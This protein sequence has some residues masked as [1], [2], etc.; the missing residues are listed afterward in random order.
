MTEASHG[1]QNSERRPEKVYAALDAVAHLEQEERYDELIPVYQDLVGRFPE[2][3]ELLFKMATLMMRNG[4]LR[5]SVAHLRKVLFMK[6]EHL[7]ARTN[8]GN[9]L[10]LLG[11]EEQ[12]QE[13]FEAVLEAD[14]ANRNALYGMATILTK[15]HVHHEA[16]PY[17]RKLVEQI[18]NSAPALA[19]L[20]DAL[21]A[22]TKNESAV[23]QYRNALK[24]N[25]SYV[26]ALVGLAKVLLQRKK[27][28]EAQSYLTHAHSLQPRNVDVLVTTGI[29]YMQENNLTS[30]VESF[31]LAHACEADNVLALLYLSMGKRK[32]GL[33]Y[34]GVSHAAQAWRLA[35]SNKQIGNAL[36]SAL[37][38]A[39]ATDAARDVLTSI[40]RGAEVNEATHSTIREIEYLAAQGYERPTPP[41]KP[42]QQESAEAT[43]EA[44]EET[45]PSTQ[46]TEQVVPSAEEQ[47]EREEIIMEQS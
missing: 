2:D 18:P 16:E 42:A 23:L 14:P 11:Y 4:D 26:P 28:E 3:V 38:A 20:G 46:V 35:P 37:A 22:D 12:A 19:L 29:A 45:S 32:Q 17:A 13:A 43:T 21:S 10:L 31:E 5:E 25:S 44:A 30:A 33:V 36:G 8:M 47:N 39:G 40:S 41:P 6:P 24:I 7:P 1:T 9:A 34:A 27:P 15:R